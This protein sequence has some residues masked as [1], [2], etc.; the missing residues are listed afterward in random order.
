MKL[1]QGSWWA[2]GST[3]VLLSAVFLSWPQ[4][5]L[6]VAT[7]LQSSDG[8][9]AANRL[10]TAQ[11]VYLWAP[12]IGWMLTLG[13]LV[14]LWLRWRRP[15]RIARGLW[16]RALAWLLVLLIGVGA[17]VH[18]G[19]KNQVGRPRP[20]QVQEM[21]GVSPFV[22]ALQLSTHCDRNCSFVSG[23]AAIGFCLKAFGMWAAPARRRRWWMFGLLAGSGIGFVRMAQGGHFLS[24]VLF[25]FWA[26][27]AS[28]LLV[29]HIWLHWRAYRLRQL[30]ARWQ[31]S[32][33]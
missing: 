24:D 32:A 27:W 33:A 10:F 16:R 31:P 5:D 3:L 18:E 8:T 28:S 21:G 12:R 17:V 26:I 6:W 7:A 19:L 4:L 11:A 20:H 23:H 15:G 22:P 1:R 2:L 13:V 14:V 25:S 30:T 9:F 29:R